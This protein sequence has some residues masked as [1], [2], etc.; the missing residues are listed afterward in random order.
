MDAQIDNFANTRLDIISYIGVPAALSLFQKA[1]FS[2]T[3][4]S[5]DFINNYLTP[6]VTS[7]EYKLDSPELFVTTMISRL[8]TQL[9]VIFLITHNLCFK[10][11]ILI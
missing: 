4:G 6:E 9:T 3:I 10:I 5:N 7:S 1:L 2:V 11:K 8:R